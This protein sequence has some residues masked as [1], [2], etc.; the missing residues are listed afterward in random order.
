MARRVTAKDLRSRFNKFYYASNPLSSILGNT[1]DY[2]NA[3]VYGWNCDIY[4]VGTD[5]V[6]MWGYRSTFGKKI[7]HE[8]WEKYHLQAKEIWRKF[9]N[10]T[11]RQNELEK[12]KSAFL[13]ELKAL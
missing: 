10:F 2:Y 4:V 1:P 7:P 3:G 11:E 8:L 5:T 9:P 12:N 13:E 6:V